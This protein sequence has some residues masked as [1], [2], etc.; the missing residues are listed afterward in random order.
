MT[1]PKPPLR[2][3]TEKNV[4]CPVD[5]FNCTSKSGFFKFPLHMCALSMKFPLIFLQKRCIFLSPVR[6]GLLFNGCL[7]RHSPFRPPAFP[8]RASPPPPSRR[9][10]AADG[11]ADSCRT[12]WCSL[13]V[14]GLVAA[15]PSA[16]VDV[17]FSQ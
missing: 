13:A 8:F 3:N 2:S 7:L 5:H 10:V 1:A 17:S 4:P 12:V 11:G 6:A 16:S 9:S 15:P 14:A